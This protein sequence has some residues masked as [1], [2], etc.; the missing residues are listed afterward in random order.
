MH[1][2]PNPKATQSTHKLGL[3]NARHNIPKQTMPGL[4][5]SSVIHESTSKNATLR[6]F[7]MWSIGLEQKKA[8]KA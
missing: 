8:K 6:T 7:F 2:L 1:I 3:V 4:L 5:S